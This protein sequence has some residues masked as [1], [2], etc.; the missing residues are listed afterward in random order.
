MRFSDYLKMESQWTHTLNGADAKVTTGS[1]LLDMFG[2]LPA[3]RNRSGLE[4]IRMFDLAYAE[5]PLTALRCL[6]YTRDI[7][8]GQGERDIFRLLLKHL[9]Q[10]SPQAVLKNLEV[11]PEYGRFDDLYCLIATPVEPRM[12][13]LMR[14]IPRTRRPR[15]WESTPQRSWDILCM[16]I[17]GFPPVC[18]NTRMW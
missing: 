10:K 7:R 17:N 11:I 13:A 1:A 8:G 15:S 18:A 6:F 16:T 12:W 2:T 5:D 4:I 14:A 9:A 3:M